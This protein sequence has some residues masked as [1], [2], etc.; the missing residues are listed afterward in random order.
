MQTR[1]QEDAK[2]NANKEIEKQQ[3]RH[4]AA[5]DKG[6]VANK[7]NEKVRYKLILLKQST[8]HIIHGIMELNEVPLSS[9]T[10]HF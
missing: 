4:K 9:G 10:A 6:N 7:N 8:S 1:P 2:Q 3:Q 5:A